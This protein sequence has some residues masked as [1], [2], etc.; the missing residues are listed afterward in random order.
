VLEVEGEPSRLI[1][2]WQGA[3]LAVIVDAVRSGRAAGSLMRF[4]AGAAPLPVAVSA[5]S[6]HALGLGEAIELGRALGRLPRRLVVY[7][8]EGACFEAGSDL[9]PAVSDAV[10]RGADAV[11][12][13]LGSSDPVAGNSLESLE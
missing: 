2:A 9:S 3:A 7:A 13:E 6:T 1:D 5:A 11:L 10:E 12:A 4:D 8:I